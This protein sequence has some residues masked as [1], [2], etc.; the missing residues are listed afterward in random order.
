MS[1]EST[2]Y[3]LRYKRS[4]LRLSSSPRLNVVIPKVSESIINREPYFSQTDHQTLVRFVLDPSYVA[5]PKDQGSLSS[6]SHALAHKIK[7][8]DRI[9]VKLTSDRFTLNKRDLR[10]CLGHVEQ[11]K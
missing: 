11:G 5:L 6:S 3:S 9:K 10:T 1:K 7:V 8:R 4:N 2:N